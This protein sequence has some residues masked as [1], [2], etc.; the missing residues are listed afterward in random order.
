MADGHVLYEKLVSNLRGHRSLLPLPCPPSPPRPAGKS[1]RVRARFLRARQLWT[2]ACSTIVA[3]NELGAPAS[4]TA[5]AHSNLVVARVRGV[6]AVSRAWLHVFA[7]VA[8]LRR[9]R[10]DAAKQCPTG[11]AVL[12]RLARREGEDGYGRSVRLPTYIPFEGARM[13]EPG[14]HQPVDMLRWLPSNLAEIYGNE[15][16]MMRPGA[17]DDPVLQSLCRRY[18]SVLGP[19]SEWIAY[20]GRA[21][22]RPLWE[23][24]PAAAAR[25]TMS[26]AA[27]GKKDGHELRKIL[28]SVPFNQMMF[29]PQELL[30]EDL[31]Y[32][33]DGGAAVT[34]MELASAS[35]EMRSCALDLSNA[36]TFV[37][38]PPHFWPYMAGPAV[39]ASEL[40]AEWVAGRWSAETWLRPQYR[41][42]GM[43]MSHAVLILQT[44]VTKVVERIFVRNAALTTGFLL[45]AALLRE[46][47]VEM[48]FPP[49]ALPVVAAY[50]HL[51]DVGFFSVDRG[52]CDQVRSWVCDELNL[53]NFKVTLEEPEESGKYIGYRLCRRRSRWEPAAVKL[54]LLSLLLADL[55]ARAWLDVDL[56]GTVLGIYTWSGLL[57]RPSLSVPEDIYRVV[58]EQRGGMVRATAALRNELRWMMAVLP[59]MFSDMHRQKSAVVLAQ[60]AAGGSTRARKAPGM[61]TG[62]SKLPCV[63]PVPSTDRP[64]FFLEA[65]G[66]TT[67]K[68]TL[69]GT[70][71]KSTL[72]CVPESRGERNVADCGAFCLALGVFPQEEVREALA[73]LRV[74]GRGRALPCSGG[75]EV[76]PGAP[77]PLVSRTVLPKRWFAADGAWTRVLARRWKA[78]MGIYE[79][80]LRAATMWAELLATAAESRGK[81]FLS[82][83]DNFGVVAV[84]TRGRQSQRAFNR[85][86]RR[87]MVAEAIGGFRFRVTW[88]DTWHQPGDGGT[89][90]DESGRLRIGP[91]LGRKRTIT[92]VCGDAEGIKVDTWAGKPDV[93]VFPFDGSDVSAFP[94]RFLRFLETGLVDTVWV[95]LRVLPWDLDRVA[96][97][98]MVCK[99]VKIDL[100]FDFLS[101][102]EIDAWTKGWPQLGAVQIRCPECVLN[103]NLKCRVVRLQGPRNK[104][105]HLRGYRGSTNVC[106]QCGRPRRAHDDDRLDHPGVVGR[107]APALRE[108]AGQGPSVERGP[109]LG[110]VLVERRPQTIDA[111]KLPASGRQL[112]CARG[113]AEQDVGHGARRRQRGG[114]V[115]VR[116]AEGDG[117]SDGGSAGKGVPLA[118][119]G[120]A[121]EQAG[122]DREALYDAACPPQANEL[123]SCSRASLRSLDVRLASSRRASSTSMEVGLAT[124]R[125]PTTP[126]RRLPMASS[127]WAAAGD[128]TGPK[129]G[130]QVWTRRNSHGPAER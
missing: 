64:T 112:L 122:L 57:W 20:L 65:P 8:R 130:D 58:R 102:P 36:Y 126:D 54:G 118:E 70:T 14:D 103:V 56:L 100:V 3:L 99:R 82:I 67:G 46:R 80:E 25:A 6:D 83:S 17:C 111:K 106:L 59:F 16:K 13:A 22:V 92:A 9:A 90:P 72:P 21:C 116:I 51:D 38:T 29:T 15:K 61:T 81:E 28:M 7:E 109:Y 24:A 124:I 76:W 2:E 105:Q 129:T 71:G 98:E 45:N 108:V 74:T 34:Q 104:I 114:G 73:H 84:M 68:S 27:V 5:G 107:L 30:G 88:V 79:G 50:A 11:A 125:S 60:D 110:S 127:P 115:R 62:K 37:Q 89:R 42:L 63:L 32:G 120:D 94:S 53:M 26:V 123:A 1:H 19:R 119:G 87:R 35:V 93:H 49:S 12:E 69:P 44:M 78:P 128:S 75:G 96:L 117:R 43:G 41:R 18:D 52:W 39:Q 101:S 48:T 4:A 66:T 85:Q 31:D 40:P 47:R 86:C 113:E 91:V 77:E 97:L 95:R 121:L 23:L 55:C 10:R 33:L